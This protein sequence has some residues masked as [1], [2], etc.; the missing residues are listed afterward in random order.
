[1]IDL[2]VASRV[3][4]GVFGL[5][6][7]A[8]APA[9]PMDAVPPLDPCIPEPVIPGGR[10]E[11]GVGAVF[12][13]IVDDQDVTLQLGIRELWQI[14]VNARVHDMKVDEQ[15]GVVNFA[16]FDQA[17]AKISLEIGCRL[18]AFVDLGSGHQLDS[19]YAI[20]LSPRETPMEGARLTLQLEVRDHEGRRA[21]DERRVP[22]HFPQ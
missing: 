11:L 6:A 21:T 10:S 3:M 2:W 18:R 8:N 5:W 22:I 1:M 17:G 20:S 15:A 13:S 7:C 12:T 16:A 9:A 14:V 4:A 19:P